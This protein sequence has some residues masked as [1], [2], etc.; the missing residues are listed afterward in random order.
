[1]VSSCLRIEAR[2][3]KIAGTAPVLSIAYGYARVS[4]DGPTLDAQLTALQDV[5]KNDVELHNKRI[6][7][8]SANARELAF[9]LGVGNMTNPNTGYPFLLT[10]VAQQL[11]FP[12]GVTSAIF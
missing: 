3:P 7:N 12:I 9:A 10:Q 4:T 11:G 8:L 6:E 1:M 2:W 5:P